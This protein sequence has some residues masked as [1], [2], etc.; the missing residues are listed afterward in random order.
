MR[1][2]FEKAHILGSLIK[3]NSFHTKR[4][5]YVI[6]LYNYEGEIFFYKYKDGQLVECVNLSEK[7]CT[8]ASEK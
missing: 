7:R 3:Q 8:Y 6:N 1:P 5:T 2:E 4:G